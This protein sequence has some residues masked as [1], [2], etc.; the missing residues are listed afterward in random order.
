ML[1]EICWFSPVTRTSFRIM[2]SIVGPMTAAQFAIDISNI[3]LPS[4][5]GQYQR[6]RLYNVLAKCCRLADEFSN[7]TFMVLRKQ[8]RNNIPLSR[9]FKEAKEI[10]AA[11]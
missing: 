6:R 10:I 8:G 4:I 11:L 7:G 5:F 3:V 9:K 2:S 1:I